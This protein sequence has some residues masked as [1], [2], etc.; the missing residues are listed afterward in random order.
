MLDNIFNAIKKIKEYFSNL[1]N[2]G[3]SQWKNNL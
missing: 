1:L 3:E 2:E